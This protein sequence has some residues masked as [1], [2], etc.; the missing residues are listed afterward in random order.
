VTIT[1]TDE[2]REKVDKA[3]RSV[4]GSNSQIDWE[5]VSQDMWVWMLENP[6]QYESYISLEDPFKQLKKVAKQEM[7]KANNAWEWYSGQYTYAPTEVRGLLNEYLFDVT[8]EAIAEHTDLVEGLLMLK[9]DAPG[10]FKTVIE[11]WVHDRE[12]N[13]S[14]TTKAVDKLTILMN[15]VNQAARYSYEGP[16]SRKALTNTQSI[17]RKDGAWSE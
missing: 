1:I 10:Y 12:P 5:D 7:Y 13:S 6:A 4:A 14:T 2:F 16:G 9:S 15:K 17:A 8:I 11:K 3:A